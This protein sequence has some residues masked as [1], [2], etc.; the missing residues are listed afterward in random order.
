MEYIAAKTVVSAYGENSNWFGTNYNMNIYKGCCHGC[1]YCDSRSDC[2]HV[3][4]FDTVRAKENALEL[5]R[6]DLRRKVKTGVVGTGAMSDPYN[7]FEKQLKLTRNALELINAY[8]FGAAIATKSD[9]ITRDIDVLRDIATHSPV[10]CK[11]TVTAAEDDVCAIT[12]PNVCRTSVR[13][14]A[15]SRL[16]SAGLFTGVLL[17]P[18]LPFITDNPENIRGIVRMAHES[19][20][21]FVYAAMGM[22]LRN[23]QRMHYYQKLDADFPGLTQRYIQAYGDTYSCSVPQA[24]KL[25]RIFVQACEEYGLLYR[26]QDII[27]GYKQGYGN[28]Q[29]SFL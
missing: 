29:L 1:I 26:M 22:T 12:E 9:L 27:R 11:I 7:P 20:A 6:N 19:G 28:T 4:R 25:W 8:G 3:D 16:S 24:S 15:I 5:I 14:A 13:F 2:Y 17:M 21:K 10:L 23:N 18:V